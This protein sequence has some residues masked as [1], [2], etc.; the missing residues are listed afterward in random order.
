MLDALGDR[1]SA[2][3]SLSAEIHRMSCSHNMSVGGKKL[4]PLC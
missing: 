2:Q 4:Q 3:L 1:A